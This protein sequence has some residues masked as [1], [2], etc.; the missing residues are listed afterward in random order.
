MNYDFWHFL[1]VQ[2]VKHKVIWTFVSFAMQ[3]LRKGHPIHPQRIK[4][5]E[6]NTKV[7]AC[8]N[9]TL[10]YSSFAYVSFLISRNNNSFSFKKISKLLFLFFLFQSDVKFCIFYIDICQKNGSDFAITIWHII[11]TDVNTLLESM[12]I[13]TRKLFNEKP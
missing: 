5:L 9:L 4:E 6:I 2:I 10:K 11:N 7:S 1:S 3:T 8:R 13:D 12:P